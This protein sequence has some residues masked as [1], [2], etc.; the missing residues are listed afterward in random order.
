MVVKGIITSRRRGRRK[1]A[2]NREEARLI[3]ESI[4]SALGGNDAISTAHVCEQLPHLIVTIV[5]LLRMKTASSAVTLGT[6]E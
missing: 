1:A 4:L 5:V 2:K 3:A 6:A